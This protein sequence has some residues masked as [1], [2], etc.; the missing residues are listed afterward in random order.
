MEENEFRILTQKFNS[1]ITYFHYIKP[2]DSYLSKKSN[3][4]KCYVQLTSP[5]LASQ[6]IDE[7]NKPFFDSKGSQFIPSAEP[8][9]YQEVSTFTP[10]TQEILTHPDFLRFSEGFDKGEIE[11]IVEK[12]EQVKIEKVSHLLLSLKTESE[13]A[14]KKKEE[15]KKNNKKINW[16]NKNK[17][18]KKK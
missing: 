1:D 11:D 12:E 6:F 8:S 9:F 18:W 2:K 4:S 10:N 3:K 16:K 7:F 13:E 5:E 14:G 15:I 17:K